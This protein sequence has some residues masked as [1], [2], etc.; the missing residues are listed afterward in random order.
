MAVD[1][2][3]LSQIMLRLLGGVLITKTMVLSSDSMSSTSTPTLGMQFEQIRVLEF[4]SLE[5]ETPFPR[6]FLDVLK[7]EHQNPFTLRKGF[8]GFDAIYLYRSLMK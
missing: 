5:V 8:D 3:S 7:M 2:E 4:Y 1:K 6:S